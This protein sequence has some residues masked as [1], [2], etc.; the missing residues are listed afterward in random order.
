M[1]TAGIRRSYDKVA[2]E[3]PDVEYPSGGRT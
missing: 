2:A 1:D 3:Y